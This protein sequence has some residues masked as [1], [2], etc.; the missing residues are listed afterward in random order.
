MKESTLQVKVHEYL[1]EK[2]IFHFSVP[3]EH[4]NI[5]FAERAHLKKMG[6]VSGI[7]DMA[8]LSHGTIYFMEFKTMTGKLNESQERIIPILKRRGYNV[9]VI[10]S[11]EQAKKQ[12]DEWG[13][14]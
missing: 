4:W 9:A 12:L 1:S 6:L 10:R 8:I 13:I 11:L 7:P 3:N 14:V 2:G 5:S